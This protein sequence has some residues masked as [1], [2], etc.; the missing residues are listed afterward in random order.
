MKGRAKKVKDLEF[1]GSFLSLVF[2]VDSP[3]LMH[4]PNAQHCSVALTP[5][6]HGNAS[7]A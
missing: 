5:E 1:Y 6:L 2:T 3:T 7:G 4:P